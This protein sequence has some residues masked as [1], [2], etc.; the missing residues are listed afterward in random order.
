MERVLKIKP[1]V[2]MPAEVSY[3]FPGSSD[4]GGKVRLLHFIKELSWAALPLRKVNQ[5]RHLSS[6]SSTTLAIG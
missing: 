1:M 6:L 3:S 4:L 5:C 2:S